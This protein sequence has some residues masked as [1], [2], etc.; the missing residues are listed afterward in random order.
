MDTLSLIDDEVRASFPGLSDEEI[1]EFYEAGKLAAEDHRTP[2]SSVDCHLA[3]VCRQLGFD[4][5]RAYLTATTGTCELTSEDLWA[6]STAGEYL[7]AASEAALF[8]SFYGAASEATS[9]KTVMARKDGLKSL[10][11]SLSNYR[12]LE[13]V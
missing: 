6:I 1:A 2:V 10:T 12:M 9:R 5:L 3:I 11:L 8:S 4:G 13:E 7:R